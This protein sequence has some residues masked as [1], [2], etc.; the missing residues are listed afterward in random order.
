MPLTLA[1]RVKVCDIALI[2]CNAYI[3]ARYSFTFLACEQTPPP[4]PPLTLRGGGRLSPGSESSVSRV[5]QGVSIQF[6]R[7]HTDVF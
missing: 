1:V 2:Y 5:I 6:F 4:S 3:S 7:G